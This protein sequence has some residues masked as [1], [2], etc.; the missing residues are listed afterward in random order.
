MSLLYLGQR[1]NDQRRLIRMNYDLSQS[2]HLVSQLPCKWMTKAEEITTCHLS[3][4]S[5]QEQK[6]LG[7]QASQW[8]I[9]ILKVQLTSQFLNMFNVKKAIKGQRRNWCFSVPI[10]HSSKV[11]EKLNDVVALALSPIIT[12]FTWATLATFWDY[13]PQ[14]LSN[15][16]KQNK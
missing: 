6:V 3:K 12:F 10:Q 4:I 15:R 9:K 16:R 5:K 8:L 1:K 7:G 11:M 14:H 2:L 13:S